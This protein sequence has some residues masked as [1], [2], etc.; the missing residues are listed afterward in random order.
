M[1]RIL[2]QLPKLNFTSGLI[3]LL[4]VLLVVSIF[5]NW[6]NAVL[7]PPTI[8]IVAFSPESNAVVSPQS[9]LSF[10][11]SNEVPVE[12][13]ALIDTL[14]TGYR[15]EKVGD[16]GFTVRSTDLQLGRHEVTI[17]YKGNQIHAWSFSVVDPNSIPDNSTTLP[18]DA[19]IQYG[20]KKPDYEGLYKTLP[21]IG[22]Y[23]S[24]EQRAG[25]IV[26]NFDLD[27][28]ISKQGAIMYLSQYDIAVTDVLLEFVPYP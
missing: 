16:K 8:S 22:P 14:G 11:V 28:E 5:A 26:V 19:Q 4:A 6:L 12:D 10:S 23:Y 15:L 1:Q 24:L 17:T 20:E 2:K 13:M 7:N 18:N 9:T 25:K 3:L 21:F 27:N